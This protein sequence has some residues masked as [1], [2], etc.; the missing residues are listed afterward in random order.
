[1]ARLLVMVSSGADHSVVRAL[2]ALAPSADY[3]GGLIAKAY[4]AEEWLDCDCHGP[5]AAQQ[6]ERELAALPPLA[7]PFPMAEALTNP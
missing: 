1:M 4:E 5:V 7:V 2:A 6:L 3:P